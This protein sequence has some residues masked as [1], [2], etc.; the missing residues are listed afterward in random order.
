MKIDNEWE[1]R[2]PIQPV[3]LS[4]KGAWE[5]ENQIRPKKSMPLA[6]R[7]NEHPIQSGGQERVEKSETKRGKDARSLLTACLPPAPRSV[8]T[9]CKWVE[10]RGEDNPSAGPSFSMEGR[11]KPGARKGD[12]QPHPKP[13]QLGGEGESKSCKYT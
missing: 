3:L 13:S 11:R 1:G 6:P 7:H 12:A 2:G 9:L 8:R 5:H 10:G 4:Q